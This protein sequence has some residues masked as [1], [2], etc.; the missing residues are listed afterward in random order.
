MANDRTAGLLINIR[1]RL[2]DQR[3]ERWDDAH[4]I[5]LLNKQ[6]KILS[7]DR[8]LLIAEVD[9]PLVPGQNV[10]SMP[11]DSY[12]VLRVLGVDSQVLPVYSHSKMDKNIVNIRQQCMANVRQYNTTTTS[13]RQFNFEG[14]A[15]WETDEADEPLAVIFDKLTPNTF[16]IYPKFTSAEEST[17]QVNGPVANLN[18]YGIITGGSTAL[19]GAFTGYEFLSNSGDT[20]S[21]SLKV[22]YTREP[23]DI[24]D[25]DSVLEVPSIFD[26]V[27]EYQVASL[28][29]RD[30]SDT[31]SRQLSTDYMKF[32]EVEL[33]KLTENQADSY[34]QSSSSTRVGNYYNG[35]N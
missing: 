17:L 35:F 5:R 31:L 32:S 25:I 24:I 15:S 16:K 21:Y 10:Y 28:A 14:T 7:V 9:I 34:H 8:K 13:G 19:Y 1:D 12:R 27:L 23:K 29:F 3:K 26:I 20:D 11:T 22:Y 2:S 6:Q 30:D 18:T 4:L 33:M